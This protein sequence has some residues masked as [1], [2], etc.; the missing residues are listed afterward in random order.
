MFTMPAKHTSSSPLVYNRSSD[1]LQ[2][3]CN[4]MQTQLPSYICISVTHLPQA[5][6][7]MVF[8]MVHVKSLRQ[9]KKSHI[10]LC[11]LFHRI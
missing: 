5:M 8:H 2:T 6:P 4:S 1:Q 7:K 10:R 9:N 3:F 11:K